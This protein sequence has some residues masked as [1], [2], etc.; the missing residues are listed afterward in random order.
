MCTQ[1][2]VCICECVCQVPAVVECQAARADTPAPSGT[3]VDLV[4]KSVSTQDLLL[5]LPENLEGVV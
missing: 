5:E 1:V 3:G 2:Y 4:E